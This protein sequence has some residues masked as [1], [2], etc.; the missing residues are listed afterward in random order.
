MNVRVQQVYAIMYIVFII[1]KPELWY[2]TILRLW[3]ISTQRHLWKPYTIEYLLSKWC[4]LHIH[5]FIYKTFRKQWKSSMQLKT[6][7]LNRIRL[8]L[9]YKTGKRLNLRKIQTIVQSEIKMN[10]WTTLLITVLMGIRNHWWIKQL[11]AAQDL[12]QQITIIK[13]IKQLL[14]WNQRYH[15]CSYTCKGN[16]SRSQRRRKLSK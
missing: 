1:G 8:I 7:K 12:N 11:L 10:L 15:G 9:E 14:E 6:T 13:E 3:L 4:K 16:R 5:F 2:I